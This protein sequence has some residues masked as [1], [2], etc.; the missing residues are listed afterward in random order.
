MQ[1]T[2][3]FIYDTMKKKPTKKLAK[4]VANKSKSEKIKLHMQDW[5]SKKNSKF[6]NANCYREF[7][8]E[9]YDRISK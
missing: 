3:Y 5:H 1:T 2:L 7:F 4:Q 9:E 6:A 8:W